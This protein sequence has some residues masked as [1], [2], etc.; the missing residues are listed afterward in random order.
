MIAE[1]EGGPSRHFIEEFC[2]QMGGLALLVPISTDVAKEH[3]TVESG[4]DVK[5]KDSGKKATIQR[6]AVTE[7][8]HKP[9]GSNK[10]DKA[11]AE[12]W[13]KYHDD[14]REQKLKRSSFVVEKYPIKLFNDCI[15]RGSSS[16]FPVRDDHFKTQLVEH[17]GKY[18][19][20]TSLEELI[21]KAKDYYR[22][23]GRV[24]LHILVDAEYTLSST[25]M[26]ELLRNGKWT[27]SEM[28]FRRHF[29]IA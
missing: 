11:N 27:W 13:V 17:I 9:A 22:A 19:P 18:D 16:Y 14:H 23:I 24:M 3:L 12:W 2:K 28:E 20:E 25:V 4:W 21:K 15:D 7:K 26:P 6:E 10:S 5:V 8:K 1:D 29:L